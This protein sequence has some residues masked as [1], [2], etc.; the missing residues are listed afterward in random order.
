LRASKYTSG[1]A[2]MRAMASQTASVPK[3]KPFRALRMRR[4]RGRVSRRTR[5]VEE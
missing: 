2:S 3:A 4:R 5:S 1:P